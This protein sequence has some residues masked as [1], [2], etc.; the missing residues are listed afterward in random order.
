[1]TTFDNFRFSK[2]INIVSK[3]NIFLR[4]NIQWLDLGCNN[5][6]FP[7]ILIGLGCYVTG[8]DMDPLGPQEMNTQS[9]EYFKYNIAEGAFPLRSSSF[10]VVSGLEIIEHIDDTDKFIDEVYR[11]LKPG[12]YF[13]LSTPNICMLRNRLRML[14]GLYPHAMEYRN[15][16]L[17]H[18][19]L[20][21]LKFLI[22]Q[23]KEHNFRLLLAEGMH[24]LPQKWLRYGWVIKL[25]DFLAMIFPGL[26]S[27]LV[28][29]VKRE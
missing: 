24:L 2:V 4:T 10:D 8:I 6:D 18:I 15:T 7:K 1:M 19:R 14:F 29:L 13:V 20:Y 3:H 21:N 23:L 28:V 9:W 22:S 26:C 11:V 27:N 17:H 5:G 16:R 12:G 25:S